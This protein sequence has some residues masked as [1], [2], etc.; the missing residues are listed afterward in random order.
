MIELQEIKRVGM[1]LPFPPSVNNYWRKSPR[2]MYLTKRAL[3]F[4][5]MTIEV[6]GHRT[7]PIFGN[8]ELRIE[9]YLC[10]PDARVRDL[11]NFAGKAIFDALMGAKVFTDDSQ[12]KHIESMFVEP[13][14]AKGYCDIILEEI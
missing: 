6:V 11:D 4:K 3:D 2:G 8:E 9:M 14:G 13:N 10:P 5:L 12:I 7:E 1:Q